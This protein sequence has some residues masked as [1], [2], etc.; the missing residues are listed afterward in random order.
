MFEEALFEVAAIL[1]SL[2]FC[3]SIVEVWPDMELS[4]M[5]A[6]SLTAKV[7]M[8][9]TN[10]AIVHELR[11]LLCKISLGTLQFVLFLSGD[12]MGG[13]VG[14]I[15][16]AVETEYD[17]RSKKGCFIFPQ[18]PKVNRPRNCRIATT[19]ERDVPVE[20]PVVPPVG[21]IPIC[22]PCKATALQK[23]G[24]TWWKARMHSSSYQ[25]LL[26]C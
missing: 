22:A 23:R 14:V 5:A 3:D 8:A 7:R 25:L 2:A 24:F 10:S 26:H 13:G 16:V 9:Q 21:A 1:R 20:H 4:G 19:I 11:L 15:W 18:P 6:T 17:V 12:G